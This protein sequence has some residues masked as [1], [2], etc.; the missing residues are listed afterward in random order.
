MG[1]KIIINGGRTNL[2]MDGMNRVVLETCSS[3]DKIVEKDK[4]VM[5]VPHDINT[6]FYER[7]KVFNRIRIK[8][9]IFPF[10]KYWNLLCIDIAG[11]LQKR[12]VVNF[13][14]R[15]S[16]FGGGINM[17][18]D[19]IPISYYKTKDRKYYKIIHRLLNK[20]DCV[21]FPTEYTKE[22]VDAAIGGES[23][24]EV[25]KLG[26]QH[27]LDIVKDDSIFSEYKIIN[28]GR[29]FFSVSQISPHKN[30]KFIFEVAKRNPDQQFV[31][32]G[33]ANRGYGFEFSEL[34]N[35]ISV[36]RISDERVKALMAGCRAYICPSLSEGAGMP[37]MEALSCGVPVL[38]SDIGVLHEY[39]CDS[40]HYFDPYDF[41][42]NLD[43]ILLKKVSDATDALEKL[44]WDKSAQELRNIVEKYGRI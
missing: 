8:R 19:I 18:H 5:V 38:V 36:G 7:I 24:K 10:F 30:F 42:I 32:A 6:E 17:L 25:M 34:S 11:V 27:Y 22:E 2:S 9:T 12:C 3:L 31:V 29:Y 33:A 40:V 20:S 39:G 44:S 15:C 41:D 16:P 4:Y 21:V 37:P 35:I 26:W 1:K 13:S 14:N 23:P 43:E 28:K